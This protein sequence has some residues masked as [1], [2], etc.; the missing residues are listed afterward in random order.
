MGKWARFCSTKTWICIPLLG[1]PEQRSPHTASCGM[2]LPQP[3]L[4]CREGW[5]QLHMG[6]LPPG[7][8][9]PLSS[10]SCRI[11]MFCAFV[12]FG[13]QQPSSQAGEGAGVKWAPLSALLQPVLPQLTV[14]APHSH[15]FFPLRLLLLTA[16]LAAVPAFLPGKHCPGPRPRHAAIAQSSREPLL[17]SSTNPASPT[18]VCV[19]KCWLWV[20]LWKQPFHMLSWRDLF[21]GYTLT[22][23]PMSSLEA[24]TLPSPWGRC[25]WAVHIC[26]QPWPSMLKLNWLWGW[27]AWLWGGALTKGRW[28]LGRL[29]VPL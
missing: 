6:M 26:E 22:A 4:C 25:R 20:L 28:G 29:Q 2:A 18:G 16:D 19:Q 1:V 5:S 21:P 15:K 27:S 7:W 10:C 17:C 11:P 3:L 23:V 24:G 9:P 14:P 8:T 12:S 13:R